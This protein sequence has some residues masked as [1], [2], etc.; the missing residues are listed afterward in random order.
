MDHKSPS[1]D[2]E[3]V[4]EAPGEEEIAPQECLKKF[5]LNKL[6][7]RRVIVSIDLLLE[8]Y[9]CRTGSNVH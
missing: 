6:L 2:E 3:N 7:Q 4:S 5:G 8:R 9:V 1:G